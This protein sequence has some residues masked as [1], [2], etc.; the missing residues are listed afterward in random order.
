[1]T[2][3][4]RDSIAD[5]PNPSKRAGRSTAAAFAAEKVKGPPRG[6]GKPQALRDIRKKRQIQKSRA[7]AD[8]KQSRQ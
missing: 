4:S 2:N 1:V 6:A 7:D 3:A 5:R 8:K